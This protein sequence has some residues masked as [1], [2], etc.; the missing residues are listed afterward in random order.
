MGGRDTPSPGLEM[1]ASWSAG[2]FERMG[3]VRAGDDGSYV[4]RYV[5]G[6]VGPDQF[7]QSVSAPNVAGILEGSDPLLKEEYVVF[8]AHMDHVGIGTPNA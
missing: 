2:E 5:I 8:S 3:L 6:T 1:T 4:Q 7:R